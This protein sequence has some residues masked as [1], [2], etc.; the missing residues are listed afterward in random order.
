M[1]EIF[2]FHVEL[3]EITPAIWRRLEIRA[4]GTFW[5]LHCAIQDAMP[6]EDRH[7]HE[8]QFPTGDQATRIGITGDYFEDAEPLLASWETPLKDWFVTVPGHC[9]YVYD[10]GDDWVH[11]VILESRHAAEPKVRYPRCTAGERRGPP[12][13]VGGPYG[14]SDFLEAVTDRR[15]P[16]HRANLEWVGGPWDPEDFHREEIVFS[17][18]GVRLRQTGLG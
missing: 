15:H 16:E 17:K 14:Y 18:P 8:F 5:H 6:W 12:E 13:D 2:V 11:T 4:E 9:L 1:K 10:F 3:E 7:L